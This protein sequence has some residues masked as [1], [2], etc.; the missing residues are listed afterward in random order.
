MNI[1]KAIKHLSKDPLMKKLI[2]ENKKPVVRN[3]GTNFKIL[4]SSIVYQQLAG[5]AAATI[6]GR[7]ENL[8]GKV[9]PENVSKLTVEQLRSA[10]LSN[11]KASYMLDLAAKFQDG[12]IKYRSFKKMSNEEIIENLTQVKG[13]GPWTSQMFLMFGLNREDVYSPFDYA[14]KKGIQ[15]LLKLDELPTNKE[16]EKIAERWAPYRTVAS[17]YLWKSIDN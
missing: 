6:Y 16:A 3:R 14:L 12:T 4:A 17:I 5:K 8:V 15:N 2:T 7:F 10:G 13:I 11:M 1:D 9:T